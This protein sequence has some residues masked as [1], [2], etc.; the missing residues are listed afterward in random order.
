MSDKIERITRRPSQLVSVVA[1][2]QTRL[3]VDPHSLV[4][5]VGAIGGLQRMHF[6]DARRVAVERLRRRHRTLDNCVAKSAKR[7]AAISCGRCTTSA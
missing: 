5:P 6:Y 1:Q 7:F 3:L 4:R 2:R